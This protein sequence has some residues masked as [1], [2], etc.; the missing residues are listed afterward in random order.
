[1][2]VNLLIPSRIRYN[3]SVSEL[4]GFQ[5]LVRKMSA[6]NVKIDNRA[7]GLGVTLQKLTAYVMY[8]LK[9]ALSYICNACLCIPI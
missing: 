8:G 4:W 5:I 1:M 2:F 6:L 7:G 9:L 3:K